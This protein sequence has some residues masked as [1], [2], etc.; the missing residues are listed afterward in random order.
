MTIQS[1]N[2]IPRVS[3]KAYKPSQ[4]SE[5]VNQDLLSVTSHAS[6][7]T[8][9]RSRR[10]LSRV[11]SMTRT[12]EHDETPFTSHRN[13][14]SAEFA[15]QPAPGSFD[16]DLL[17]H[18][19][20]QERHLVQLRSDIIQ[21]RVEL[22]NHRDFFRIQRSRARDIDARYQQA[23]REHAN[24]P[25]NPTTLATLQKS[26]QEL[27]THR[28]N[29]E[30]L[31]ERYDELETDLDQMDFEYSK[32]EEIFMAQLQEI[33]HGVTSPM[34]NGVQYQSPEPAVTPSIDPLL[35]D[36]YSRVGDITVLED[37]IRDLSQDFELNTRN[38][39]F[40]SS[41]GD[42]PRKSRVDDLNHFHKQWEIL[43]GQLHTARI[44]AADLLL[45]CYN[46]GLEPDPE[47]VAQATDILDAAEELRYGKY[48]TLFRLPYGDSKT[49]S[50]L[51]S[52]FKDTR[53]RINR[54]LLDGLRISEVEARRHRSFLPQDLAQIEDRDWAGLV[55]KFWHKDEY[56]RN[57]RL[58]VAS[59]SG[60]QSNRSRVD[61]SR[62]RRLL[63]TQWDGSGRGHGRR[64][65]GL[66]SSDGVRPH[67]M[68]W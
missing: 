15:P 20:P 31:E 27:E 46:Q 48:P 67:S 26:L 36:Y 6:S 25:G 7:G 49:P 59:S 54:W 33:F 60:A 41:P 66:A 3:Q 47:A 1:F 13:S 32:R 21:R 39:S 28:D 68:D 34:M 8:D 52:G 43:R 45:K 35:M 44:E 65:S 57:S 51:L 40:Q 61:Y 2:A 24:D 5:V 11:S 14:F 50:E 9:R 4:A 63:G 53:D 37:R 62:Y 30:P 42:L 23:I 55:W 58:S 17:R 16:R 19:I 64:Y 22:H 12:R 38:T 10:T 56:A 29:L 18:M